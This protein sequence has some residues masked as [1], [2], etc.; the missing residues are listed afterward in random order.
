MSAPSAPT[1]ASRCIWLVVQTT[2]DNGIAGWSAEGAGGEQ[3]CKQASRQQ[4]DEQ[5]ALDSGPTEQQEA[6]QVEPSCI[7]SKTANRHA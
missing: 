1:T 6:E 2:R 5:S 4:V 7:R 3:S